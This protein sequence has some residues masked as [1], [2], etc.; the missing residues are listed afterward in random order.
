MEPYPHD[1]SADPH[2][3]PRPRSSPARMLLA[4]ITLALFAA[5]LVAEALGS[6]GLEETSL[7]Y[8]GI[9]A[10]IAVTVV[11]TARPKN[12]VGV[13]LATTT[14]G[15]ALAGPLLDEGVVCLLIAAP[16]FYGVAALVGLL[17]QAARG[18]GHRALVAAPLL[19]LIALE[20][21]GG[22]NLI[23]RHDNAGTTVTIGAAPARVEAA[24]A[25]P[26]E[27]GPYEAPFL[28]ALPFPK[29]VRATGSGLSVGD[30]RLIAFTPRRSL[31]LGSTPT[32]RSM[33]LR[34]VESTS[35]ADAGRVVFDVT[36]DSTLARWLDLRR[37]VVTWSASAG[38][39]EMTWRLEYART[40]DPSWYFGP[41]QHHAVADAAGY[42]AETFADTAEAE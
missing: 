15:L 19:A 29:P 1:S 12:A 26:P 38:G 14:V 17:A 7:F 10:L 42:L 8:V 36:A 34:V 5:M 27:F 33:E 23:P 22:V 6:A 30:A 20:G 21:V 4:G 41:V 3:D 11:L 16:L 35:T 37:A 18:G 9:P 24:L 25:A 40:F 31:G 13:A 28:R 32:P 2:D 39:T